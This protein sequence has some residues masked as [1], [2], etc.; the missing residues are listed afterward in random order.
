[1][2]NCKPNKKAAE[3][4]DN[5]SASASFCLAYTSSPKKLVICSS[6]TPGS[7]LNKQLYNL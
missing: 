5:L 1:M 6:E 7:Q 2:K 3:A 4:S